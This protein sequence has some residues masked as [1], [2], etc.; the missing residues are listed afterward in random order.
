MDLQARPR[1]SRLYSGKGRSPSKK[2]I[3]GQRRVALVKKKE[4][5]H[6]EVSGKPRLSERRRCDENL[7]CLRCRF[8][9]PLS[10]I[11]QDPPPEVRT[12]LSKR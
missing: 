5:G 1:W 2:S 4:E 9:G 10:I 3:G 8:P 12:H 11:V 7:C 6:T